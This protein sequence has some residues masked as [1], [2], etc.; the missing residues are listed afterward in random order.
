MTVLKARNKEQP[1]SD[2]TSFDSTG[3]VQWG[4]TQTPGRG[5]TPQSRQRM[6]KIQVRLRVGW[7]EAVW[8]VD[9]KWHGALWAQEFSQAWQWAACECPPLQAYALQTGVWTCEMRCYHGPGHQGGPD[10][11]ETLQWGWGWY[12]P[13]PRAASVLPSW[14]SL[15]CLWYPM[16][17][18]DPCPLAERLQSRTPSSGGPPLC[19][20][21]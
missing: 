16:V 11:P 2:G 10:H 1:R 15:A 7:A 9:A 3:V 20:P 14:G 19:L 6:Q 21:W 13:F 17:S 5:H 8:W 4:S 12:A 18:A